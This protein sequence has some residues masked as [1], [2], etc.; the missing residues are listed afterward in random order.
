MHAETVLSIKT[1]GLEM[2]QV[3]RMNE[4]V[5]SA[6][7]HFVLSWPSGEMPTDRQAEAAVRATLSALCMS[8]H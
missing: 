3:A 4:R 8:D 2:A 5:K 6:V 7:Y 1:A